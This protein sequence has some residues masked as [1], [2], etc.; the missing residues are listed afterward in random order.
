MSIY[1][2]VLTSIRTSTHSRTHM[3][4][5]IRTSTHSR[6]HMNEQKHTHTLTHNTLNI[7]MHTRTH[8]CTNTKQIHSEAYT[9]YT[10]YIKQTYAGC[11][12]VLNMIFIKQTFC[13]W[14]RRE[15]HSTIRQVLQST[16]KIKS[17]CSLSRLYHGLLKETEQWATLS[18][19]AEST[20]DWYIKFVPLRTPLILRTHCLA[21][22]P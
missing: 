9:H 14:K 2:H 1:N 16:G 11:R 6:T 12:R 18:V 21:F 15:Y 5:N 13:K 17:F 8:T 20:G 3:N 22:V 7:H 10:W 19:H 4:K